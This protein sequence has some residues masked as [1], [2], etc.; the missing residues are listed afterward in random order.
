MVPSVRVV[1]A[2]M[3]VWDSVHRAASLLRVDSPSTNAVLSAMCHHRRAP[4]VTLLPSL[5]M[6]VCTAGVMVSRTWM[7]H[8]I[9]FYG[10]NVV[11]T[12]KGIQAAVAVP[13]CSSRGTWPNLE[14]FWK[15]RLVVNVLI[16]ML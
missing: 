3:V 4:M 15:I 14:Y 13:K 9:L 8:C 7:I 6:A 1:K 12:M 16:V 5:L 11:V 10:G 2:A